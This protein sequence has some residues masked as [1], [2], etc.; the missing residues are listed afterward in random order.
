MSETPCAKLG[1]VVADA[2]LELFRHE[3]R[4]SSPYWWRRASMLKLEKVGLV[5]RYQPR[6][7]SRAQ[8][9]RLTLAG[10]AVA[11]AYTPTGAQE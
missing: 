9:W 8:A 1:K 10:R 7:I 5:E 3:T 11:A 2:L 4:R 6:T